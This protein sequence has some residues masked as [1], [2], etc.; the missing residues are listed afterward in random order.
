MLTW[1]TTC[2]SS[3]CWDPPPSSSSTTEYY[4]Q[5]KNRTIHSMAGL[6]PTSYHTSPPPTLHHSSAP[7]LPVAAPIWFKSLVLAYHAANGFDQF[8]IKNMVNPCAPARNLWL[9]KSLLYSLMG[10]PAASQQNIDHLLSWIHKCG[11]SSPL[12][13]GPL[14]PYPSSAT[15]WEHLFRL[16]PGPWWK[17]QIIYNN[18]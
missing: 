2:W 4:N 15:G 5:L 9:P 11:T 7:W 16:H 3:W 6:Q 8:Y 12:T 17:K 1:W 14:Q 18:N 13:T 10:S